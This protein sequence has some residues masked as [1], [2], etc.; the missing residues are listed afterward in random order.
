M[1]E[2]AAIFQILES[3]KSCDSVVK[4]AERAIIGVVVQDNIYKLAQFVLQIQ[5]VSIRNEGCV[6]F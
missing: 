6:G 3:G 1:R 2:G 4:G 5:G